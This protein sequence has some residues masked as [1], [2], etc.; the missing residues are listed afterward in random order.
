MTDAT[1]AERWLPTPG[2]E[3]LYEV[4]DLGRVRSLL[5]R[6]RQ[7]CRGGKVLK[8]WAKAA[9][10]V[11]VT[12][13]SDGIRRKFYVHQLVALAFI[14]PCPPG[15]EVRHGR[16][17]PAD[18]RLVNLCYGTRSENMLDAVDHGTHRWAGVTHCIHNHE[19]TPGNTY[20]IPT[21]GSR[22]CRMCHA[23]AMA[24]FLAKRDKVG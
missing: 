23:D 20:I 17:G 7:G 9:G 2:Y 21:T 6:T 5:H 24:R 15:Q 14:G 4:S 22:Q 8:P 10:Y 1:P 18:N 16:G 13:F 11:A 19:Y 12:L 3:H